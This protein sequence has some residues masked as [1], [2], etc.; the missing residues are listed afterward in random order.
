MTEKKQSRGCQ[1]DIDNLPKKAHNQ[2]RYNLVLEASARAYQLRKG[3][4][5]VYSDG[6]P[7]NSAP[8]TALLEIQNG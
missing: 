8:M 1:L 3:R 4:I 6:H 7:L 2:N 5:S